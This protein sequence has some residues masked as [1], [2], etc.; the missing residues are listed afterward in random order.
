MNCDYGHQKFL[1]QLHNERAIVNRALERVERRTAEILYKK[2]KWFKWVRQ[3]Q[4]EEEA[5]RDKEQKKVKQE[6]ALFRR[7][8]K[9]VQQRMTELRAKEEQQMQEAFLEKAYK[10]RLAEQEEEDEDESDWD[11]IE[12]VLED[13]RGKFIGMLLLNK[14]LELQLLRSVA[15]DL[16]RH[17]LWMVVPEKVADNDLHADVK[18]TEDAV[19]ESRKAA[20]EENGNKQNPG[21][22]FSNGTEPES[23]ETLYSTQERDIDNSNQENKSSSSKK[24][25]ASKKKKTKASAGE[26]PPQSP[27]AT[28]SSTKPAAISNGNKSQALTNVSKSSK[29]K[30]K[31]EN[32]PKPQELDKSLIETREEMYYRLK[33]G[34]EYNLDEVVGVM[35]AGTIE[36]PVVATKTITYPDNQI[37]V[38]LSEIAEIK[39][40]LFCRLLLGHAA[41]LP[42]ALRA[43]SVETFLSDPEVTESALRDLCLKMERPGL[44]EIRDACADL[45]RSENEEADNEL[46][47]DEDINEETGDAEDDSD[48]DMMILKPE[49]PKGALPDTWLSKREKARDKMPNMPSSE[50]LLGGKGRGGTVVD[51]GEIKDDGKFQKKMIR[52]EI[53]GQT[54]W[55]YPSSKAMTRKGWLHFCIIAKDSSLYDAIAL[56]RHWDEF[57]DLN[58]LSVWH[59][60]PGANWLNWVGNRWRQQMLQL[61]FIMYFESAEPDAMDLTRH[62]QTGRGGPFKRSYSMLEARNFICAH[63]KRDDPV[64]RRFIQY[65]HMQSHRLLMLVRDAETGRILVKPP[66]DE[67]WLIRGKSGMG[68]AAKGE[69]NTIKSVGP[70]FF[71]EM[72]SYRKWNFGFKEYYDI[73]L[74]DLQIGESFPALYNAVQEVSWL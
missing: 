52:V 21:G 10:E 9:E 42:A 58:I 53:C 49:K 37:E 25:R 16:I 17:F 72:D 27:A 48:F 32:Q 26:Q 70:E 65:L 20:D 47:N 55:N 35:V 64:S 29:G 69:W 13:Q 68:R 28:A 46:P 51:F 63:I 61:G 19:G 38:L 57:F 2:Q 23:T 71:E 22:E 18:E 43:D 36:N 73:I 30:K 34:S 62:H 11:P 45:F 15:T 12:D 40:L 66:E 5:H 14:I 50:E 31:A 44:Q 54:I 24:S 74:W 4:D 1:D 7:H 6:A 59:Y 33:H 60:F 67:R 39:H 8:W 41:L 56:C 3:C